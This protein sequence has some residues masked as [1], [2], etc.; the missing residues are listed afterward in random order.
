LTLALEKPIPIRRQFQIYAGLTLVGIL[1]LTFLTASTTY[2]SMGSALRY[3]AFQTVAILTT[4]GYATADFDQ[5]VPAAKILLVLLMIVGGC[6]GSTSGGV[7]MIRAMVFLKSGLREIRRLIYPRALIPLKIG[8]KPVK[9]DVVQ[10]VMAFFA[11]YVL[12]FVIAVLLM[13]SLGLDLITAVTSIIA[14]LGNIGPGLGGVG[15]AQ[16]YAHIPGL[17]KL[18]L[19]WCMLLGRLEIYTVLILF[20][21]ECWKK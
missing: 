21:P 1:A 6:A 10:G 7:K 13:S 9:P 14:T 16:N 19:C 11:L 17:G 12:C 2:D 15:P 8:G 20:S 5:W 4:T 18:V 3:S